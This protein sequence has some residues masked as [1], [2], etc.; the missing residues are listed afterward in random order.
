MGSKN[1]PR[2][3]ID[4]R[5]ACFRLQVRASRIHRTGVFAAEDIP[6]GC[7]VIE[8]TGERLTAR[9]ANER[10]AKICGL[11]GSGRL[12]I[13]HLDRHRCVDGAVGGSG[14]ELIN[15]SCDPNLLSRR[16]RGHILYFSRRRVHAGE[17]LTVDYRFRR[18]AISVPCNCGSPRC[19]RTINRK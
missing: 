12:C 10:L 11:G 16:V 14:A 2:R 19:R 13:F 1:T 6:R 4:V 3:S 15:H 8:Y 18:N 7:K 17:E 9:E 5:L